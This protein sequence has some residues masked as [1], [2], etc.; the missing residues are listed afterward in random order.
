[1]IP[2]DPKKA[3]KLGES[4]GS[5]L[6]DS[7]F[8]IVD[9]FKNK[10]AMKAA[11][12]R[13]V[14]AQN[15]IIDANNKITRQNNALR[16]QAIREIARDQELS[17]LAKMSPSQRQAYHQAKAEAAHEEAR[18]LRAA[19]R[20][21]EERSELF[22]GLFILLFILPAIVYLVLLLVGVATAD[23]WQMYDFFRHIP[24]VPL[25]SGHR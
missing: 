13:K 3:Q 19:Q 15:A 7:I 8:G 22:W 21:A 24:G 9:I 17:A 23:N 10:D 1:M 16:A 25:L 14:L 6:A 5:V 11:A 2:M 18:A 4:W 12:N 20:R